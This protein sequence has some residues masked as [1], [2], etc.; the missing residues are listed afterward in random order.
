MSKDGVGGGGGD[1]SSF[2]A[3]PRRHLSLIKGRVLGEF[4]PDLRRERRNIG[5]IDAVARP[6]VLARAGPRS[7]RRGGGGERKK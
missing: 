6:A 7:G 1:I 3:A 5:G 4:T 2:V